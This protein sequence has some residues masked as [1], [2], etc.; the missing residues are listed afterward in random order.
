MHVSEFVGTVLAGSP[1]IWWLSQVAAVLI[2]VLLVLRWHPGFLGGRTIG[3]SVT[4]TLDA[5]EQQIKVQL[6]AAQRSREEAARIRE[7]SEHDVTRAREE[8]ATIVKRAT[9]TSQAIQQEL[10]DRAE[11]EYRRIV[12]QARTQIDYERRQAE[13]ALQRR[14]GDIA[15]DAAREIIKGNL[16]S[17]ADHRLIQESLTRFERVE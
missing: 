11:Q 14:A 17:T 7:Q 12:G 10:Q 15:V 9:A 1:L 8:A 13:V 16:D 3:E 4:A 5:R 2:I 6:E